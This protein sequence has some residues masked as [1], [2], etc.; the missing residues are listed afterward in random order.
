MCYNISIMN[1]ETII[2]ELLDKKLIEIGESIDYAKFC[3]VREQSGYTNIKEYDFAQIL[4]IS[5]TNFRNIRDRNQ[6]AVILKEL[7]PQKEQKQR[8]QIEKDLIGDKKVEPGERI[9]YQKFCNLHESYSHIPEPVFARFLEL[10]YDT[11][12]NMKRG[13]P[14]IVFKSKYNEEEMV[15]KIIEE[16][17]VTPGEKL[18]YTQFLERL[19]LIKKH[20]PATRHFSEYAIA[21]LLGV[22]KGN[23]GHCKRDNT[24]IIILKQ[25]VKRKK[26]YN[27]PEEERNQV[28]EELIKNKNARPYQYCDYERFLELYS[29]YEER[30]TEKTF[31]EMLDLT[32]RDF[33]QIK[34]QKGKKRIL[35]DCFS[36]E[37][38]TEELLQSGKITIGEEISLDKFNRLHRE[39]DY[40]DKKTFAEILEMTEGELENLKAGYTQK[41]QMLKSKIPEKRRLSGQ[42]IKNEEKNQALKMLGELFQKGVIQYNQKI[43]YIEFKKLYSYLGKTRIPEH[44][45]AEMLG[46]P[47]FQ[48]Q[49][50][51][52]IGKE[53]KI[54]NYK[55]VEAIRI[56][57]TLEKRFYSKEE[58]EEI[59]TKHNI[60]LEEFIENIILKW[61]AE[62][63]LERY[64]K[65][66]SDIFEK[67]KGIYIGKGR[68]SN[69][70]FQMLYPKIEPAIYRLI[71][72]I[73]KSRNILHIAE[74]CRSEAL[75]YILEKCGDIEQNFSDSDDGETA[76]RMILVRVKWFV[77]SKILEECRIN[78]KITSK[79]RYYRRNSKENQM[80]D[81]QDNKANTE[82]LA[83]ENVM[84]ETTEAK[85]MCDLII[86]NENG[87]ERDELFNRIY[88]KYNVREEELLQLLENRLMKK[89][90]REK[91]AKR[92]I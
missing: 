67:H 14:A 30:Y 27:I 79:D 40:F 36:K 91:K 83:I 76:I 41:V 6:K 3:Y 39:Y 82:S 43:N 81:V 88:R 60:S 69:R 77:R 38:V 89:R 24:N 28:V 80:L 85:I 51:R 31:Y 15:E 84:N 73:C 8:E 92:V 70:Y 1:K 65:L 71:G 17:L 75:I 4:G 2:K 86:G 37:R 13:I 87:I 68:M 34:K 59:I 29:G 66:Y 53:I 35:R 48:Y 74:D 5:N 90:D 62:E 18:N 46:I 47:Y 58:I 44:E 10:T 22:R 33:Y 21:K 72:Y 12:Y 19:E 56:I 64:I 25:Y 57:G 32:Y 54:K 55:T 26:K 63:D 49:N 45:V 20:H 11:A 16:K 78:K 7:I 61:I 50:M 9:D 52:H 23:L 42:E